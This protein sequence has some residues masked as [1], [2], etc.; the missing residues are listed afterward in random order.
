MTGLQ[1]REWEKEWSDLKMNSIEFL[2]IKI[3]DIR[4]KNLV[5]E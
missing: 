3:I 4:M 1:G 2:E 5:S